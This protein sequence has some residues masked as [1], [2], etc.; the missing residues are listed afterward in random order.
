M[1]RS[2]LLHYRRLLLLLLL[3]VTLLGVQLVQDSPLHQ[4]TQHTVDCALCHFQLSDDSEHSP[5]WHV[6]VAPQCPQLGLVAV[7]AAFDPTP[8]PY[9][10]R[11]P[12]RA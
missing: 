12:P 11:A 2:P 7:V 8:T 10:S 5:Q 3:S 4:H 9:Q 1:T 6:F